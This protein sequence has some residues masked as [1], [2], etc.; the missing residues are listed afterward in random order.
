MKVV[1][2]QICVQMHLQKKNSYSLAQTILNGKPG[3]AM[4]AWRDKF[5]KAD[6]DKMVDYLQHFKGMKIKVLT[7]AN[8]KK[9]WKKINDRMA[10]M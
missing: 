6:A 3:T 7:L 10:L 2:V 8:V 4:P 9:G 5:S 1:L